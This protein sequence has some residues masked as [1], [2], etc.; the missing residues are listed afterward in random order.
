MSITTYIELLGKGAR[1]RVTEMSGR[2][3]IVSFDLFGCVQ[4][5]L[6]PPVDKDGK[7]LDGLW[8]DVHRLEIT[9]ESRCMPSPVLSAHDVSTH[10][11][12]LG[13]GVRDRVTNFA[14]RV[15]SVMF[16]LH[17]NL[18]VTVQPLI[19]K[20]GKRAD[21]TSFDVRRLEITDEAR[22]M[23]VPTFSVAPPQYGA[24]PQQHVHGPAE[25]PAP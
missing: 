7:R 21:G 25:K 12:L 10:L 17:G 13:K 14:G 23:P 24:T 9:I 22:C 2:I 5:A 6:Q 20:D 15:T 3:T 4:A 19:D 1:D 18:L 16:D 8:F 11:E